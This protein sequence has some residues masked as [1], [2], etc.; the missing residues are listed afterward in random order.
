MHEVSVAVLGASGHTGRFVVD[1]LQALGVVPRPATRSGRFRNREQ[2]ELPCAT[3][4]FGDP[5]GLD[6][7]LQ[8]V[9]AVINCAG[10]FFDT[11][12]PAAEAAVRAGIPYVDVTAEQVTVTWL[13]EKLDDRARDAGVTILPAMG[14]FGGLADLMASSLVPPGKRVDTV[15]IAVGLDSW[16]PT[17]GTRRTAERNIYSRRIIHEGKLI[18]IPSPAPA[19]RW[20]FPPPLGDQPVICV[21]LS[22]IVLIARH[23]AARSVT[24]FMNEQPIEDL[25]DA[26]TPPPIADDGEGRSAQRF[27]MEVRVTAG[28]E[29]SR[30]MASGRDIYAVSA[31]LAVNACLSLVQNRTAASGVRAPGEIFDPRTFLS[32]MEP[33]IAVTFQ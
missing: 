14:F 21:A 9:D 15:E 25:H 11:A 1:R 19:G 8:G 2:I 29:E 17:A 7:A 23:I 20:N 18:P 10:P 5:P 26:G 31:P 24:S 22:E 4:D 30:A 13:I 33:D 27:F 32:A 16:N 3:L 28:G 12:L 6:R